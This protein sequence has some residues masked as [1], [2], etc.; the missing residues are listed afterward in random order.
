MPKALTRPIRSL[1]SG[2]GIR[3]VFHS[4]HGRRYLVPLECTSLKYLFFT[5]DDKYEPEV[6]QQILDLASPGAV[7]FDIGAHLGKYVV[8]L[9]DR[10]RPSGRLT[11]F[12]A[13][14]MTALYLRQIVDFNHL[15][16]TV[17]VINGAVGD[18]IGEISIGVKGLGVDPSQTVFETQGVRPCQIPSLTIDNYCST[19]GVYPN[20]IKIDV[21]GYELKVLQ[22]ARRTLQE[23]SPTICCEIHPN[24]LAK[25]GTRAEEV[26]LYLNQAGYTPAP[27]ICHE[28]GEPGHNWP[29]NLVFHKRTAPQLRRKNNSVR[30]A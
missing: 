5:R 3:T 19:T 30:L 14:P 7:V 27:G 28:H 2:I 23:S 26:L 25:L 8:G 10:I 22:G 6:Y 18:T 20:L 11:A 29:Y 15:H 24:N 16:E 1:L 21:E 12:E 13:N 4:I 17:K 9:A